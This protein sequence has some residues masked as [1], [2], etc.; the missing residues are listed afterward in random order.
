MKIELDLGTV[1]ID[2]PS[3]KLCYLTEA[4]FKIQKLVLKHFFQSVILIFAKYYMNLTTKP[5]TCDKCGNNKHFK[6]KTK[7]GKPTQLLTIFGRVKLK[8][9]QIQCKHCDHKMY[10]VR[11]L[12][13]VL[14]RKIIPFETVKRLG[15]IGALTSFRVASKITSMFGWQLD[16]MTVWRS[17]Q[18]LAPTIEFGLDINESAS[19]EADGTGIPTI[20]VKKRGREL[21]VFVQHKKGG[22]V[23]IANLSIGNYDSG[24]DKLFNPL[25][26]TMKKFNQFLLITDGDTSILNSI[27]DKVTILFQRCLWHLPHQFK[28]YLWKDGVTRKSDEWLYALAKLLNICSTRSLIYDEE[29][30]ADMVKQKKMDY[31]ELVDYCSSHNWK[32]AV[33]YLSNAADDLFTAVDNK[34]NG[35][36][37]SHVERVMRTVNMRINVGKWSP[38]GALNAAKVRLAYY[39]N[40]FDV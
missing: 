2:I 39:Y 10:I 6:W 23:R 40:D 21:K 8:Q 3:A 35:K 28:Y 29:I 13:S 19:G 25:L 27:K 37:T 17:L 36:T 33:T 4:F 15:L 24:W 7:H 1:T 22:G 16:K 5:F 9:L 20:G 34:L 26:N 30:T 12:L 11:K 18:K 32:H 38:K 14:P 31:Q